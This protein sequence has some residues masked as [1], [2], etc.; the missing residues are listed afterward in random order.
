MYVLIKAE[1]RENQSDTLVNAWTSASE[2]KT[3]DKGWLWFKCIH[4]S[5]WEKNLWHYI[6]V[7]QRKEKGTVLKKFLSR[8]DV[9]SQTKIYNAIDEKLQH[10]SSQFYFLLTWPNFSFSPHLDPQQL[11]PS[12][13]S[14]LRFLAISVG[15]LLFYWCSLVY[16][17]FLVHY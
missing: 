13:T 15:L 12:F 4:P 17:L 2:R 7:Y 8:P 9:K 10:A 1:T 14:Y 11:R 6:Q 16:Y 5:I 3:I